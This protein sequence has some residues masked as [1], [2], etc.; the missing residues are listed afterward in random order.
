MAAA[1]EAVTGP[2]VA[3]VGLGC[4]DGVK[5]ARLL[6]LLMERKREISFVPCDVSLPL[7]LSA[8]KRAEAAASRSSWRPLLCDLA[9]AEDLAATIEALL[10]SRRRE[11][12]GR[13]SR[14][15]GS[16][17]KPLSRKSFPAS[18]IPSPREAREKG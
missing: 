18:L 5:E 17:A 2:R 12:S 7:L 1:V 15:R 16:R 9:E 3:V 8:A 14:E 11:S 10:L 13:G 4:G 6:R